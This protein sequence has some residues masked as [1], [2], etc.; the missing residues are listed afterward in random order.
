MARALFSF[1]LSFFTFVA[2]CAMANARGSSL[3]GETFVLDAGHG[4]LHADGTPL[5]VGAVGPD[6]IEEAN[7]TL[8]VAEDLRALVERSGGKAVLT[9]S[10]AKRF[11]VAYDIPH[12]NHARAALANRIGATAFI[13]IHAD[14]STS[15]ESRGTSV[16]WLRPNSVPLANAMRAQLAKLGLGESE[17]HPRHLAVTDEARVP[18]VL[19]ELG[20]VSNPTQE[21][22]LAKPEFQAREASVLFRAIQE[23]FGR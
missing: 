9:R 11:R 3:A 14:S 6:G 19:V 4:T 16:F 2:M 23:T 12:D 21:R 13:A 17:F 8:A 20:F 10:Y 18:A 1:V 5:N 7:V 15:P 22:L